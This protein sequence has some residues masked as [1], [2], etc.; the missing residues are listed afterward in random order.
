ML[1][2]HRNKHLWSVCAHTHTWMRFRKSMERALKREK[3]ETLWLKSLIKRETE[4]WRQ[5]RTR[6]S[7]SISVLRLWLS[8]RNRLILTAGRLCRVAPACDWWW[9]PPRSRRCHR[10]RQPLAS[11][12]VSWQG[13]FFG[14]WAGRGAWRAGGASRPGQTRLLCWGCCGCL[15]RWTAVS[16]SD[17]HGCIWKTTSA[18]GGSFQ[19]HRPHRQSPRRPL[20]LWGCTARNEEAQTPPGKPSGHSPASCGHIF[21]EA[22]WSAQW[23]KW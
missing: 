1:Y 15:S 9:A 12:C 2:M 16:H 21:Y 10:P 4:I 23:Q 5:N 20:S 14:S 22:V 19:S 13:C 8:S 3:V 17:G 7:G 11:S 18:A 6:G